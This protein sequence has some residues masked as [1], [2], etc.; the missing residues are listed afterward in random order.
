MVIKTPNC[1]LITSSILIILYSYFYI[2]TL[3]YWRYYYTYIYIY[4]QLKTLSTLYTWT[5]FH[6][7][8]SLPK[9]SLTKLTG[10]IHKNTSLSRNACWLNNNHTKHAVNIIFLSSIFQ[11][12]SDSN[13]NSI[14]RVSLKT[15]QC[16]GSYQIIVYRGQDTP[17]YF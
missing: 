1:I 4:K 6:S 3:F 10:F 11:Y 13:P 9:L 8:A 12:I 16:L 7:L 5:P 15:H 14:G 2:T 17:V